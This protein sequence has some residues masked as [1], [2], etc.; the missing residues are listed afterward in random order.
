MPFY[1]ELKLKCQKKLRGAYILVKKPHIK[2][3]TKNISYRYNVG[4]IG[5]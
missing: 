2:I 1:E 3:I 5:F 4:L